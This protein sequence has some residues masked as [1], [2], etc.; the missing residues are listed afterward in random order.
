MASDSVSEGSRTCVEARAGLLSWWGRQDRQR[1]CIVPHSI[2]PIGLVDCNS[3]R[4]SRSC[5][6]HGKGLYPIVLWSDIQR[7]PTCPNPLTSF[8]SLRDR[9]DCQSSR[10]NY[11][12][13]FSRQHCKA[14]LLLGTY[15]APSFGTPFPSTMSWQGK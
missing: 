15:P 12:N 1:K 13:A 4:C 5:G 8:L 10:C 11:S 9:Q 14:S 2:T 7:L 3:Y 6:R